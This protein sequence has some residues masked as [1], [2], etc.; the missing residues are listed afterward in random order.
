MISVP[1]S[2]YNAATI[3]EMIINSMSDGY[4]RYELIYNESNKPIDIVF[5][6]AN[7]AAGKILKLNVSVFLGKRLFSIMPGIADSTFIWLEE[8][9]KVESAG[10]EICFEKYLP[11]AGK[12]VLF[13]V[14]CEQKGMFFTVFRELEQLSEN[15]TTI[16]MLNGFLM[17]YNEFPFGTIDYA[18]IAK[19]VLLLSGAK[20]SF[21]TITTDKVKKV[22]KVI[23]TAGET[24]VM[25]KVGRM[26]GFEVIGS[27]WEMDEY[28]NASNNIRGKLNAIN[29]DDKVFKNILIIPLVKLIKG[30]FGVGEMFAI[31]LYSGEDILGSIVL[32]MPSGKTLQDSKH[33]EIFAHHLSLLI[34]R[35]NSEKN[36]KAS[37]ERL[38]LALEGS[39]DSI[40]DW[41]MLNDKFTFIGRIKEMLGYEE[42]EENWDKAEDI[43]AK[44]YGGD[45]EKILRVINNLSRDNP[46]LNK[47]YR[48]KCK[49][50]DFKWINSKAKVV[51]WSDKGEPL[52]MVGTNKDITERH[53]MQEA[54]KNSEAKY[55]GLFE[56]LVHGLVFYQ[57][58][59]DENKNAEEYRILDINP[60][61][62][63]IT[64][65]TAADVVG[66]HKVKNAN[67]V[68]DADCGEKAD[69]ANVSDLI[70]LLEL[71]SKEKNIEH[72]SSSS[73]KWFDIR[74][75]SP[76]DQY[77]AAFFADLTERKRLE[78]ALINAKVFAE[79][80]NNAKSEF[81]ANISHELR[82][83]LN[84]IL[85]AI[86]LFN[87][88]LGDDN[89]YKKDKAKNH[90]VAMKQ[91][92]LRLIRL[93]N[94]I[95][96]T[97]RIDAGQFELHRKNYDIINVLRKIV[98]STEVYMNSKGL[99]LVFK[100]EIDKKIIACDINTIERSLLNLLSNAA[101]FSKP[102][103]TVTVGASLEGN[104][105]LI[106]VKDDGIGIEKDMLNMI[107]ERFKQANSL[108][109]REHEGSGIGLALIRTLIEMQ[110]GTISV[111]SQP[112]KG[113]EF[114]IS[115]PDELAD[116]MQNKETLYNNSVIERIDTEFSDIYS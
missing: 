56:N 86:Q 74:Y 116:E 28:L 42:E 87:L 62:E 22:V 88:Y 2:V 58:I 108:L 19:D 45:L 99:R 83:P 109:T 13:K 112:G 32:L 73:G 66:R 94:N 25:A 26:V 53:M 24:G 67:G 37:E 55:R 95:L 96:D 85:S 71:V 78:N 7:E 11:H 29:F 51:D 21:I 30:A 15:N 31:G 76:L 1:G 46:G 33:I 48:V 38:Q 3:N 102:S 100:P 39:R 114:T 5:H 50:G 61:F 23:A 69:G 81:L 60:A 6:N 77:G 44:I 41:D 54:I 103:G 84:V 101:K 106:T 104:K 113:S 10:D 68:D 91:N 64:G 52:R 57:P 9:I 80:A 27:E 93:V 90:L 12:L 4:V 59:M 72:Y 107:F 8:F 115:L 70:Q 43:V 98:E 82:T 20:H 111:R 89:L 40:F 35:S 34:Q 36:L 105:V 18:E 110:G 16:K 65:F 47:E 97:T 92:S 63:A 79:E 49:N 14:F 75:Y 17:K